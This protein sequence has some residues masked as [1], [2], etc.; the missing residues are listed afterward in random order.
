MESPLYLICQANA[1]ASWVTEY[2]SLEFAQQ[3]FLALME[4]TPG[5]QTYLCEVKAMKRT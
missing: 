3:Q 4:R 2:V 1:E 5:V